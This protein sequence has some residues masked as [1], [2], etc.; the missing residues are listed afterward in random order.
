[1]RMGSRAFANL[2]T[3]VDDLAVAALRRAGAIVIGKTTTSEL[4][5]L[6]VTE[7]ATHSPTRNPWDLAVTAGGSSGGAGAATAAD[8][9]SIALGSDAGGSIR[10]PSA[11]CGLVGLKPSR[12]LVP[13]PFGLDAPHV[14]WT[15]GPMTRFVEDAAVMLDALCAQAGRTPLRSPRLSRFFPGAELTGASFATLCRRAP[16]RLRIRFTTR[17]YF[18][19]DAPIKA[20]V[21]E[22][23]QRL[24]A[25]GHDVSEGH[26]LQ[27]ASVADFLPIWQVTTAAIPVKDWSCTEPFTRWLAEIG[28]QLDPDTVFARSAELG[29]S[30]L[31]WFG[32]ADVWLTP[33]VGVAPPPIGAWRN[34]AP[35]E[36]FDRAATLGAFTAPFNLSGQ[37][38]ISCP[39]A[40]SPAGHPIGV[41]LIGRPGDDALLLALAFA[42]EGE[43]RFHEQRAERARHQFW[44]PC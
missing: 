19:A 2:Y 25:L 23:A 13:N 16:L 6:P 30:V 7:P 33:T 26:A 3:P 42:L 24:A 15:C 29:R 12:G 8:L 44:A 41:Q 10:I 11:C 40:F 28:R 27:G 20:A 17:T 34:L 43:L 4:G 18:D 38:A 14:I 35:I 22:V 36:L 21:D 39:V 32:D 37:P 5:A 9:I 31:D 1:M